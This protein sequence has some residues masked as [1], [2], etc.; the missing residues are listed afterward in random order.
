M[1]PICDCR[2]CGLTGRHQEDCLVPVMAEII[3]EKDRWKAR[4]EDAVNL[5]RRQEWMGGH[6]GYCWACLG[7][8]PVHAPN[9]YLAAAIRSEP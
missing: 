2:C 3:A 7:D 9:C 1:R 6:I 4:Y 8:K 5:L